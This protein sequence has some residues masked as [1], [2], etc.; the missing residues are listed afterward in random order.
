M[1][2][3]VLKNIYKRY[4]DVQALDGIN[5]T[6]QDGEFCVIVG[7]SGSGKTTLLNIIAGFTDPDDGDVTVEGQNFPQLSPRERNIGMVFQDIALFSHMTVRKNISFGLEIKKKNK[8]EIDERLQDIAERLKIDNLLDKKPGMLSGGEAQRVGI[9]RTLISEPTFFLFDEPLG[10]LDAELKL[11]ML[12]EIKR[13]HLNLKKTFIFVTHDQE[14]A[15]SVASRV[16]IMKD[17]KV[18]EEGHPGEIY[19]KPVSKFVAEFFGVQSMDFIDGTII[20][21]EDGSLFKGAGLNVKVNGN[22][23]S[24]YTEVTLGVR[25]VHVI[26]G[27]HSAE[28]GTGMV[29]AI[30]F[31]G[32]R[33]RIYLTLEHEQHIVA[34]TSPNVR[35]EPGERVGIKFKED[36]IFLFDNDN[37]RR[38]YP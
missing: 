8:K 33:N 29:S 21:Q 13:L 24:K 7:P 4:G 23:N 34:V 9:A 26:V 11:E 22:L 38:L 25:P 37:G 2:D 3:L 5:L 32:D 36:R 18:I 17:G 19:N 15:L 28:D 1:P 16:I 20:P 10:N 30:E 14:Q 31:L 35:P 6:I 27:T 12:T